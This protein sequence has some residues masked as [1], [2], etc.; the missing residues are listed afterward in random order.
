MDID[1]PRQRG[2][3]VTS[4]RA[5]RRWP[6][7]RS[8]TANFGGVLHIPYYGKDGSSYGDWDLTLKV[9]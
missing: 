2:A 8:K 3:Q 4:P 6:T 9:K 1:R 7:S 5:R